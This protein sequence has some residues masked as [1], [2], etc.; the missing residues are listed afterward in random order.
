MSHT[1]SK[2]TGNVDDPLAAYHGKPILSQGGPNQH[3]LGRLV[4]ELLEDG[5]PRDD[6]YKLALTAGAVD[7]NHANFTRRIAAALPVRVQ[8]DEAS[9]TSVPTQPADDPLAAYHGKPVIS[10]EGPNQHYVGRL[11]VELWADSSPLDDSYK[12]VLSSDAVD[13]DHLKFR[14]RIAIALPV[15][16]LRNPPFQSSSMPNM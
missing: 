16:V 10:R 4:V 11:I 9:T 14:Q 15:R 1:W 3:Y 5:R 13:G 8:R 6:S 2:Q 7:G 12:L